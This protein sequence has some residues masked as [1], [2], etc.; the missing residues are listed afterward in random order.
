MM[1]LSSFGPK[2]RQ[3]KKS[4]TLDLL[5]ICPCSIGDIEYKST[6][7]NHKFKVNF[8]WFFKMISFFLCEHDPM[9]N[10]DIANALGK[11]KMSL[12]T[13]NNESKQNELKMWCRTFN[14][15]NHIYRI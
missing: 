15:H 6:Y 9:K 10:W 12:S 14:I 7:N 13:T 8:F 2:K 5:N 4:K 11:L 3:K 1:N